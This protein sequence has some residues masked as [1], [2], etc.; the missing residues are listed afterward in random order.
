MVV[1]GNI[2][3]MTNCTDWH[4]DKF[5]QVCRAPRYIDQVLYIYFFLFYLFNGTDSGCHIIELCQICVYFPQVAK[6]DFFCFFVLFDPWPRSVAQCMLLG[7]PVSM[8]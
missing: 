4:Q 3:F 5:Y 7:V 1:N 2:C 6:V 8:Y